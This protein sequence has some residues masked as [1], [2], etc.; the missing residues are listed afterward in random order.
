MS[1]PSW[2][3]VEC[4]GVIGIVHDRH[5]GELIKGA[6]VSISPSNEITMT[7]KD[8][9][10]GYIKA[11]PENTFTYQVSV[12]TDE[13]GR[14]EFTDMPLGYY[15]FAISAEG[16]YGSL[17]A[18]LAVTGSKENKNICSLT[19]S[20]YFSV[21]TDYIEELERTSSVPR[22]LPGDVTRDGSVDIN[23]I[24]AVRDVIFGLLSAGHE[25]YCSADVNGD[26]IVDIKDTLFVRG[27]IF[28]GDSF[29]A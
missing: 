20:Q 6:T 11:P 17:N 21:K 3:T 27:I 1:C 16:F 9:L 8:G 19:V 15:N 7:E 18:N 13:Y 4:G 14:F 29:P 10:L 24:I 26:G 25:Y 12:L 23:D 22:T 28:G 2:Q 5:T